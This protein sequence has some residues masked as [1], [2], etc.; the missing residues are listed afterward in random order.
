MSTVLTA[1]PRSKRGEPTWEIAEFFPAQGDWSE[2]EYLE[3]DTNRLVEF[4]HGY[5]EVLP[6]PIPSHNMI[7]L[8]LCDVL[9][10]F[11]S[12]GN[13]GQ[14]L[15]AGVPIRL[16]PGVFR[17]PDIIFM[18]AGHAARRGRDYWEGADLVMEV[19]SPGGRTRDLRRKRLEY[20]AA[21]IPEYWIID[22]KL[23]RITVLRLEGD[24]YVVHGEF[25]P[26][27]LATS[28][29]LKG[30]TVDVAAA[31]AGS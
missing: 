13:L 20:A 8:Y 24:H 12:H 3:L 29:L 25:R 21:G 19:I 4:T 16:G 11:V 14:V 31:L 23:A 1:P 18:L 26:G 5:L 22:P 17:Q 9:R 6:M 7:I 15:F 27:E 2:E 10:A 30:F 28:V